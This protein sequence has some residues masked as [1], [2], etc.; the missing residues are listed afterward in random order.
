MKFDFG[1]KKHLSHFYL[2][3]VPQCIRTVKTV[4]DVIC[5][6]T[7]RTSFLCTVYTLWET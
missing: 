6:G 4:G 3:R 1:L 2:P 5:Q 7:L